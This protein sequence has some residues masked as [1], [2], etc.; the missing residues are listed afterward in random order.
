[1]RTIDKT[2]EQKFKYGI[3]GKTA[4]ISASKLRKVD[5]YEYLMF[6]RYYLPIKVK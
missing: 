2:R 6:Q 1:M 3:N 4:K 5:K